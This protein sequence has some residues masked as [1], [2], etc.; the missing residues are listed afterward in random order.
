MRRPKFDPAAWIVVPAVVLTLSS[1][2]L[3]SFRTPTHADTMSRP[4]A[5]VAPVVPST[6]TP[7]TDVRAA[8]DGDGDELLEHWGDPKYA[9]EERI[10][11]AGIGLLFVGAAAMQWKRSARRRVHVTKA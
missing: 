9:K 8:D 5:A 4:T 2:S 1:V 7:V 11:L 6:N 10:Q 3:L